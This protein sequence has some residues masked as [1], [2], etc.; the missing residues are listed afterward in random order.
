M[1]EIL[2]QK[3]LAGFCKAA[4]LRTDADKIF[5]QLLA[6]DETFDERLSLPS[7]VKLIVIKYIFFFIFHQRFSQLRISF[8][9]F[10][11]SWFL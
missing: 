6:A 10:P 5:L 2:F 1:L 3:D 7:S 11:A 4:Q 8:K 9:K